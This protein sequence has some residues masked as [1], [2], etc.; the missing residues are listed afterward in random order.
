MNTTA[1]TN[2]ICFSG[3]HRNGKT[4]LAKK[5]SGRITGGVNYPTLVSSMDLWKRIGTP[6]DNYCFAERLYIQ[7]EIFV[8]MKEMVM[9]AKMDHD[10][11]STIFLDRSPMDLIG[12]LLAN[13]DHTCSPVFDRDV[14]ELVT[15][16]VSFTKK[17]ITHTFLME[18]N[19]HIPFSPEDNKNGKVYHSY[20]Y[21][22]AISN[23]IL[24]AT[25]EHLDKF[26]Y[27]VVIPEYVFR[28]TV[29]D[30]VAITKHIIGGGTNTKSN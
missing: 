8:H 20:G 21:R 3:T 27:D 12:Y 25:L 18:I 5:V 19:P 17:H 11:G 28:N 1:T 23:N 10:E 24:A 26:R 6:S 29:N 7:K 30:V 16:I 9:A 4:C 13:I 22:K 2:I 15:D 14:E